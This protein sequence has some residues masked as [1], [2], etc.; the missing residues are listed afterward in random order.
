LPG[1][2]GRWVNPSGHPGLFLSLFF[3]KLDPIPA[4]GRP[5]PGSTR[6]AGF[7]NYD[8]VFQ[9]GRDQWDHGAGG[10]GFVPA[11][12]RQARVFALTQQDAH[13]SNIVVSG[14]LFIC[15]FKAKVLFHTRATHF[16]ISSYFTLK[17]SK[18]PNLLERPLCVAT[19]SNEVLF[20]EYVYIDYK[21]KVQGRKLLGDFRNNR[22]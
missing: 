22:F 12:Q 7:Q 20:E 1:Q 18:Q 19:P 8:N 17:F 15:S 3:L 14:T 4:P 9:G 6:Q 10:R 13:A 21:V 2:P 5:G 11:S 16:F